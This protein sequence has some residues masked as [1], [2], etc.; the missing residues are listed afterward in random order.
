MTGTLKAAFTD[1]VEERFGEDNA[2]VVMRQKSGRG[3]RFWVGDYRQPSDRNLSDKKIITDESGLITVPAAAC[4]KPNSSTERITFM[5][6]WGGG[7]QIHYQRLGSRPEIIRYT[8]EVPAAGKY[9]LTTTVAT[10]SDKQSV[11]VR[12][13]RRTLLNVMLPYTKGMWEQSKPET[14]ELREGRNSIMLT[15]RAPNRGVSIKG[16]QLKPVK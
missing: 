7:T 10:V 14:I 1:R 13:N 11:I 9:Q 6:S 8:I 3:I 5:Q 2:V 4:S 15:F 16:F 12:L